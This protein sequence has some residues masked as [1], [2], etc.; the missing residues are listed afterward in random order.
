VVRDQVRDRLDYLFEDMGEQL[1]KNI[2]R[3]IRI[4]R[5]RALGDAANIPSP[6]AL[7]AGAPSR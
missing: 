4:Y 7:L 1:V 3:P 5:V 2:A 6:P